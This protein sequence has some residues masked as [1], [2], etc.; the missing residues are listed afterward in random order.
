[1]GVITIRSRQGS[2][3]NIQSASIA[4]GIQ[5][6]NT[7]SRQNYVAK[8]F[9]VNSWDGAAQVADRATRAVSGMFGAFAAFQKEKEDDA[10]KDA[11]TKYLSQLS[12]A[13][14]DDSFDENGK[15]RGFALREGK[16]VEGSFDEFEKKGIDLKN[17]VTKGFTKRQLAEFDR[18]TAQP[19]THFTTSLMRHNAGERKKDSIATQDGLTASYLSQIQR[20][21]NIDALPDYLENFRM[22]LEKRGMDKNMI[23]ASVKAEAD[24]Q[25]GAY[26][27]R[28]MTTLA[29]DIGD[30]GAWKKILADAKDGTL[31]DKNHIALLFPDTHTVIDGKKTLVPHV[32]KQYLSGDGKGGL[33]VGKEIGEKIYKNLKTRHDEWRR[34][35]VNANQAKAD[36]LEAEIAKMKTPDIPSDPSGEAAYND[37]M[38]VHLNQIAEKYEAFADA[39]EGML[40]TNPRTYLAIREKAKAFRTTAQKYILDNAVAAEQK[41]ALDAKAEK[42]AFDDL[43]K[44]NEEEIARRFC[45]LQ[46]AKLEGSLPQEVAN[47]QQ[48]DLWRKYSSC[49]DA[50]TVSPGFM[51]SF[52]GR[53]RA[54]LTDQESAA[55]RKFYDAFG[56]AADLSPDGE[57]S[58]SDRKAAQKDKTKYY[59]PL[60][61]NG[62]KVTD[63]T[64]INA[65]DLL[66]LGDSFLSTLRSLG[67]D[68]NREGVVEKTISQIKTKW[69]KGEFDK[70][71]DNILR[72][73]MN[74]RREFLMRPVLPSRTPDKE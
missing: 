26:V 52:T 37:N 49:S 62:V 50:G 60:E 36:E 1:M 12:L 69:I 24:N 22:G 63:G 54:D 44:R 10:V 4:H 59:A 30:E 70:N 35:R 15:I 61:E 42:N 72:E 65:R 51:Q 2:G 11:T 53:I 3:G 7:G 9:A 19:M 16:D 17:E 41:K 47:A 6:T 32:M 23:E 74:I 58:A 21:N 34:D 46:I 57:V 43:V 64:Q 48:A 71:R 40:D 38:S 56:Y 8:Q 20:D 55:M 25:V 13:M 39:N 29:H 28:K 66:S 27:T 18:L 68:M 45:R 33:S 5:N 67:P 14:N 73:L 31:D